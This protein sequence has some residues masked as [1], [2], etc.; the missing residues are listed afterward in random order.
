MLKAKDRRAACTCGC[1]PGELP[2]F[3]E[4]GDKAEEEVEEVEFAGWKE[5][6]VVEEGE[7]EL[8]AQ[9]GGGGP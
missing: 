3:P 9:N 2:E 8:A 1:R 4:F 5:E 7:V 6:A